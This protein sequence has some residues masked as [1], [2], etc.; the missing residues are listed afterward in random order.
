[1]V[2]QIN[3]MKKNAPAKVTQAVPA[4]L[5]QDVLFLREIRNSL[6][7]QLLYC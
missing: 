5:A 3:R 7:K 6:K 2:K 4:A 1:M